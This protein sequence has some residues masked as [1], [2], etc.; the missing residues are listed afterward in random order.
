[1]PT[2]PPAFARGS[3]LQVE[4]LGD[5]ALLVMLGKGIDPGVNDQVHR[6]GALLRAG[7]L[8]GVHDLVPAYAT[9]TVH[10]DPAAWPGG[11]VPPHE[12]LKNEILRL[13]KRARTA[14]M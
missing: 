6:L 5:R 9:L 4:A 7:R 8:P 11:K 3:K 2:E 14:A 13:W 1:M 10:Y 12:A